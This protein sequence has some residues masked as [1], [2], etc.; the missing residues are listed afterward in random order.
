MNDTI[1]FI[2]G[3]CDHRGANY[4]NVP[5]LPDCL[6]NQVSKPRRRGIDPPKDASNLA[7]YRSNSSSEKS[8]TSQL[9]EGSAKQSTKDGVPKALQNQDKALKKL[10]G[11]TQPPAIKDSSF[12]KLIIPPTKNL[13]T[14]E[15]FLK[16]KDDLNMDMVSA[17][18]FYSIARKAKNQNTQN[19]SFT[20][21]E[22]DD[23]LA[24]L[25]KGDLAISQMVIVHNDF[26]EPPPS[27]SELAK[28]PEEYHDWKDVFDR[29]KAEQLPPHRP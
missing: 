28:L 11:N 16:E 9:V 1:V 5:S 18:S 12:S 22:L 25:N 6:T 20:M 13:P 4:E 3:F 26:E 29:K 23:H 17:A 10:Q 7:D 27:E 8:I 14:S 2:P 21:S 24:L 15:S 19:S